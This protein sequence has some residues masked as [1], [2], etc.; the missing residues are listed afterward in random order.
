MIP[1]WLQ[2]TSLWASIIADFVTILGIIT[3][4][5][6]L[7][8]KYNNRFSS[9]TVGFRIEKRRENEFLFLI[10]NFTDKEFAI[11][12]IY[13]LIDNKCIAAEEAIDNGLYFRSWVKLEPLHFYPH[14]SI[15][16]ECSFNVQIPSNCKNLKFKIET[17][18][19]T[20][21]YAINTIEP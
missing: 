7:V 9:K 2:Q 12:G 20:L 15:K 18:Q 17:T 21:F 14:S 8:S 19:K 11:T 3:I 10:S 16:K 13:L 6:T 1:L 4:T 5:I